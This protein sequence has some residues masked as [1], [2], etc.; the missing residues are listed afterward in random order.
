MPLDQPSQAPTLVFI[1]N[2]R[3]PMPNVPNRIE[4]KA[5]IVVMDKR[6]GRQLYAE[7]DLDRLLTYAVQ[8]NPEQQQ[9]VVQTNTNQFTFTFTD[10]PA[11]PAGPLQMDAEVP[12]ASA[13]A[14]SV[15]KTFSK[16]LEAF[17]KEPQ[18]KTEGN[19]RPR[20]VPPPVPWPEAAPEHEQKP[21]AA[22]APRKK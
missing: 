14:G 12:A 17:I 20:N 22:A 6:D 1:Q 7:N 13:A 8:A 18:A 11:E 15:G 21:A 4:Y 16:I 10:Q 5:S 2:V 3:T 19:A 9:V